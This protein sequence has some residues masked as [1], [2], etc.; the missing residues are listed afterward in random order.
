M[1]TVRIRLSLQWAVFATALIIAT[2]VYAHILWEAAF[3]E[4][5]SDATDR[6]SKKDIRQD[7]EYTQTA[8]AVLLQNE[9]ELREMG[10]NLTEYNPEEDDLTSAQ[11]RLKKRRRW[12][13]SVC[14]H[15]HH[16][17][18]V[19]KTAR[20]SF[21]YFFDYKAAV[22]PI[23][24]SGSSTWREHLRIVNRGP[25]PSVPIFKDLRLIKI[26]RQP[27]K[28]IMRQLSQTT[29]II[30]VRHPLTRLVSCFRSKFNKGM[31][32]R[33]Y[34]PKSEEER[35]KKKA[36]FS[37]TDNFY[38]FWLP[39]LHVNNMLPTDF[40]RDL[41]LTSP[42]DPD[43][44]YNTSVY[45]AIYWRVRP[46]ISFNQFMRLVITSHK[47]GKANPHWDTYYNR[48]SPCR[49]NYDYVTHIET[50]ED[51]LKYVFSVLGLPSRPTLDENSSR[52]R[53]RKSR[54]YRMFTWLPKPML[55]D[56][57]ELL[58]PDLQMFGYK[59]PKML[60]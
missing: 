53:P 4:I 37:W 46:R 38:A 42:L 8:I 55:D 36:G 12:I 20:N 35:R 14:R 27:I 13:Q 54:D 49:F 18:P 44:R 39:A 28:K 7:E 15:L 31:P 56:L 25:H 23:P 41:N 57:K 9:T 2:T 48:C 16:K 22:C 50:L 51:D 52:I 3:T 40:H 33:A 1:R 11:E 24:K 59:W 32:L 60:E 58:W 6:L 5:S 19:E 45:T 43:T 29:K 26:Q 10:R 30:T 34:S 17:E 47:E 21:N